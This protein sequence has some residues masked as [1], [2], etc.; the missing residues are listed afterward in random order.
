MKKEGGKI[1][2]NISLGVAGLYAL[3]FRYVNTSDNPV[4]G[5]MTVHAAD[6]T[7]LKQQDLE[8]SPSQKGKWKVAET[9]TGTMIN[10]GHYKVS[11]EM[12]EAGTLSVH[13]L[14]VQ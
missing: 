1:T 13:G 5:Q 12:K 2:W 4:H 11:L 10:A 14:E 8:L 7:L 6:G 3:R 9:S